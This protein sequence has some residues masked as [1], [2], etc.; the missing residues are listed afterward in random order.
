MVRQRIPNLA[1][2][3]NPRQELP[4]IPAPTLEGGA[5][6]RPRSRKFDPLEFVRLCEFE[7][8]WERKPSVKLTDLRTVGFQKNSVFIGNMVGSAGL[9]PATPCL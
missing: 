3:E 5:R 8:L 6:S 2:R 4:V 9:E 1:A 7:P